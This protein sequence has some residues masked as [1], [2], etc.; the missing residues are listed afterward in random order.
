MNDTILDIVNKYNGRLIDECCFAH[1]FLVH[2]DHDTDWRRVSVGAWPS[3]MGD[4][5]TMRFYTPNICVHFIDD[6][7]PDVI[8][9][10]ME[11]IKYRKA[12]RRYLS[13]AKR[14][15]PKLDFP[16]LQLQNED[17]IAIDDPELLDNIQF[18]IANNADLRDFAHMFCND[19]AI[20]RS[21]YRRLLMSAHKVPAHHVRYLHDLVELVNADRLL[22]VFPHYTYHCR[23]TTEEDVI[24]LCDELRENSRRTSHNIP[25]FLR[26]LAIDAEV[27]PAKYDFIAGCPLVSTKYVST[28]SGFGVT[29]VCIELDTCAIADDLDRDGWT[30]LMID[31]AREQL[32]IDW[33]HD[34]KFMQF[35]MSRDDTPPDI[36][37]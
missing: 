8:R 25:T 21:V 11:Y 10:F 26:A 15:G 28:Y 30:P 2:V 13:M 33:M 29:G 34:D 27:A 16:D 12:A 18:A 9:E 4:H 1:I 22:V 14:I 36:F 24:E 7:G 35:L 19:N 31:F 17:F 37:R 5:A 20:T 3:H 23:Y 6:V 32:K